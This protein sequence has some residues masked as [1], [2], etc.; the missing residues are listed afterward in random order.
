V[1]RCGLHCS[2]WLKGGGPERGGVCDLRHSS[3]TSDVVPV[4]GA[5]LRLGHGGRVGGYVPLI[6]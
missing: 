6:V 3:A 2:G 4:Y 1:A 5:F